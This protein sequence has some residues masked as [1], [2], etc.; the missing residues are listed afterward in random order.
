MASLLTASESTQ[1]VQRIAA[2]KSKNKKSW[3]QISQDFKVSRTALWELRA[4]RTCRLDTARRISKAIGWRGLRK[5]ANPEKLWRPEELQKAVGLGVENTH[6]LLMKQ[7]I[8]AAAVAIY[9]QAKFKGV[10]VNMSFPDD[11]KD[12]TGLV[13]LPRT[14]SK[15]PYRNV[16][17]YIKDRNLRYSLKQ[18]SPGG[19]TKIAG[20]GYLSEEGLVF[21]EEFLTDFSTGGERI[22]YGNKASKAFD[23]HYTHVTRGR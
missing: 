18:F 2:W 22:R 6:P 23:T 21:C 9:M 20:D 8:Y 14:A 16:G 5:R 3:K 7:I 13:T 19:D 17:F 11:L 10:T 4:G 12:F 1:L 15:F